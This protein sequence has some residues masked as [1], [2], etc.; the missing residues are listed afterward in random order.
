MNGIK[1]ESV[2]QDARPAFMLDDVKLADCHRLKLPANQLK[3]AFV[4]KQVEDFSLSR[5]KPWPDTELNRV[6]SGEI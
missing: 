3:P 6:A 5:S 4:L 2:G 1:V